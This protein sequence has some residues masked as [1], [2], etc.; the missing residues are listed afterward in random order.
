MKKPV[1]K[2][3]RKNRTSCVVGGMK[4]YSIK[5]IKSFESKAIPGTLGIF[6]FKTKKRAEEWVDFRRFFDRNKLEIIKVFPLG[7]PTTLLTICVTCNSRG[8][9]KFYQLLSSKKDVTSVSSVAPYG[10]V[11]YPS[12]LVLE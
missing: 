2:V 8:I 1:Y 12:V 5:Y 10:T 3:V 6:C 11:C 7:K 4:K 9:S